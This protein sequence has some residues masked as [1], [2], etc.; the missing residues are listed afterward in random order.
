MSLVVAF[1]SV[2][3]ALGSPLA[4]PGRVRSGPPSVLARGGFCD[5]ATGCRGGTTFFANTASD[6]YVVE[7]ASGSPHATPI[8]RFGAEVTDL[9]RTPDGR[10]FGVSF[11]SLYL[12]DQQSGRASLVG[13]LGVDDV[14][15]LVWSGQRLLASSTSGVL[16]AVDPR[17]GRATTIGAFGSDITSSGDLCFGPGG[18]LYMT[19]PQGP[20]HD[21]RDRLVRVDPVTGAAALVGETG[22]GRVYGLAWVDGA[23]TALSE[24]G[25]VARLDPATAA[26]AILGQG[27]QPFW[28]AS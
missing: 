25:V 1:L 13:P 18:A 27:G 3:A 7:L 23:L 11:D 24:S 8:G 2:I 28:G 17:T 26:A 21:P 6:L 20:S 10:L 15:G 4:A 14:N 12:V 16:H 5:P 22:L 19:D 9:A